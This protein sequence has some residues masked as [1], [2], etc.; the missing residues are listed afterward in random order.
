MPRILVAILVGLVATCGTA[1]G[2]SLSADR[3]DAAEREIKA[4]EL[5]LAGLLV[6]QQF[7]EYAKYLSALSSRVSKY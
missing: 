6:T 4:L 2:G 3:N 7:D 1:W 5:H